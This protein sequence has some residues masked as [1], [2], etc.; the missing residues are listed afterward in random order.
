MAIAL[1]WY[2]RATDPATAPPLTDLPAKN[3]PPPLETWMMTGA[4]F[5]AAASSTALQDEELFETEVGFERTVLL[6]DSLL[7]YSRMR[8]F[9]IHL[10]WYSSQQ[11]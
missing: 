10:T 3:A 11:G 6:V 9:H 2:A 5:L 4:L 1:T 7:I 8:L